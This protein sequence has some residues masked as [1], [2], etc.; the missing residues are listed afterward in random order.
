MELTFPKEMERQ[1]SKPKIT[2]RL[3]SKEID[4]FI[5]ECKRDTQ[6]CEDEMGA[7][8]MTPGEC[9]QNFNQRLRNKGVIQTLQDLKV[10]L[11]LEE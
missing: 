6:A 4:E 3:V 2:E 10:R 1:M 7:R 8:Q 5:A 9:T 11:R